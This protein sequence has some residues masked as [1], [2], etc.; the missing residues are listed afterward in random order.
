MSSP[1]IEDMLTSGQ[2]ARLAG[3]SV[4]TIASWARTGRLPSVQ[5]VGVNGLRLFRR[6]DVQHVIERRTWHRGRVR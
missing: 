4:V 5:L 2:V 3:V 6:E 1:Q